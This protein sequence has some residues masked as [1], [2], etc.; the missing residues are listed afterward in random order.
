MQQ[1]F[2]RFNRFVE[3]NLFYITQWWFPPFKRF[4]F[5]IFDRFWVIVKINCRTGNGFGGIH[6]P[7][8]ANAHTRRQPRPAVGTIQLTSP[9][10]WCLYLW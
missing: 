4:F 9:T 7:F 8:H 10:R 5:G 3:Y 1:L 6:H 2:E